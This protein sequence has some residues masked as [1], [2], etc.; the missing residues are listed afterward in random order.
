MSFASPWLLLLLL[1]VPASA[2]GY[3]W[4]ERR[5]DARAAAWARPALLPNMA[6]RPPAAHRFVPVALLL[7]GLTLLLVG[8]ARPRTTETVKQHDA[9]MILVLDVSGS[10]AAKDSRPTRIAAARALATR[11]V[12]LLPHGYRM[13]VVVF[14]D[15]AAVVAPP[16]QDLNRVRAVIAAARTG[17][18]GTALS[19]AV[20]HA[21]DAA[22]AVP[23]D[24]NGKHPPAAIVVFSDGGQTE[25]RITVAQAAAKAK[26]AHVPVSAVALGTPSGIVRQALQGGYQ[27]QIQVPVEPALLQQL[28]RATG[29]RFFDGAQAVDVRGAYRALGSRVGHHRKTLEVTSAAAGA[30]LAFMVVGAA[31]SGLWFRRL[32]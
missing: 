17:P 22:K 16:T 5:R 3:V 28:T 10:M 30:G 20:W 32:A 14:S 11:F 23:K 25:G 24:Q 19:E 1:V 31:L 12:D 15:H 13:S 9:T 8:F 26:A 29:G 2:L 18:Q 21:V 7:A 27:E 4:L 6:T